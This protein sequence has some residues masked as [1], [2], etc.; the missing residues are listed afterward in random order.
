[1]ASA[2]FVKYEAFGN[3]MIVADPAHFHQPLEPPFIIRLC[4]RHRGIGADGICYGPLP[5]KPHPSMRFFNPDGSEA[6]KSGNGLRIFARYLW[7]AGY[8][9][10]KRF[11]I[12][13]GGDVL[14]VTILDQTASRVAMGMGGLSFQSTAVGMRGAARAVVGEQLVVGDRTATITAVSVGNPHCVVFTEALETIKDWGARLEQAP[15]FTNRTN[16][17]L[18]AV[19]SRSRIRIAIWERGAGY[20][21]ASGTSACAAAGAAIRNGY[22]D[23]PVS[24]EMAGGTA[25]VAID[26]DWYATLTG[27]VSAVY[28]GTL[29]SELLR[30]SEK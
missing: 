14:P 23:S 22:C 25:T 16:V 19:Q 18:V 6:E 12:A 30:Q 11:N 4:D 21:L 7:D 1:M 5:G 2:D 3:D 17:Q 8:V 24:V 13:I 15:V 10:D 28:R 20:T 27:E 29:S 26:H 9:T